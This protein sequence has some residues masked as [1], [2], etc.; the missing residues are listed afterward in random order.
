MF[1][2]AFF[3][4]YGHQGLSPSVFS[5]SI[6]CFILDLLLFR[7]LIFKHWIHL[8]IFHVR[9]KGRKRDIGI[10][11]FPWFSLGRFETSSHPDSDSLFQG[12][13]FFSSFLRLT[14][15]SFRTWYSI[16]MIYLSMPEMP[17][18]SNC[19]SFIILLK[20]NRLIVS[21]HFPPSF[22]TLMSRIDFSIWVLQS[23]H[24]VPE[25]ERELFSFFIA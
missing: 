21:H 19:W 2:I 14:Q 8:N 24:L 9:H 25:K 1:F 4:L 6:P 16:L 13:S 20:I 23:K 5:V 12:Y 18:S 10:L 7:S 17:N 3:G 22:K 15:K 11:M